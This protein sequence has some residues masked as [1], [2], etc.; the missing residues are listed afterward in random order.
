VVIILTAPSVESVL[1]TVASRCQ[2]LNLRPAPIPAIEAALIARGTP[3]ERA[4]F[5]AQLSRGRA[6]WA[7]RAAG[8]ESLLAERRRR[9]DDLRSLLTG[10]R[11]QRFAYAERLGRADA[12][13]VG[14]VLTYWLL[15]WRDVSRLA[16]GRDGQAKVVNVDYR[17]D[18]EHLAERLGAAVA[19]TLMRAVSETMRNIDRNV[20]A[21]LA[22][23][24]LLL[25]LPHLEIEANDNS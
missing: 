1:P 10:N 7:L 8:D 2:I 15:Y 13:E 24:V 20:N 19:S 3:R 6:G 4:E 16:S 18:I 23:D 11:T 5:I 22:L 17:T 9:L 25:R 21:R 12:A 14:E